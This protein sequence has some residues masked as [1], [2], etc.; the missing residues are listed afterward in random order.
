MMSE[1]LT[2]VL[3][4]KGKMTMMSGPYVRA[5]GSVSGN[6]CGSAGMISCLWSSAA[7]VT[8]MATALCKVTGIS[9]TAALAL[10]VSVALAAPNIPAGEMPGRERQRFIES[11]VDRFTD[12]L[13]QPRTQ[14][15]Y[16]WKCD[17]RQPRKG[18]RLRDRA[19]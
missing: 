15:L 8:A 10:G 1:R 2:L 17:E 13:A 18:Q 14:P 12:P 5:D 11:P 6:A 9:L 19:C 7:P 4:L 16:R 3:Y